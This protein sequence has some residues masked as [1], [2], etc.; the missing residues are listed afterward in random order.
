MDTLYMKKKYVLIGLLRSHQRK[1]QENQ[2]K[3][4]LFIQS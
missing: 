2:R 1:I 4:N 3:I